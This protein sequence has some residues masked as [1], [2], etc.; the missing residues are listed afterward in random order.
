MRVLLI[1]GSYP[2]ENC[3]VGDYIASLARSLADLP[4]YEV[5]VLTSSDRDAGAVAATEVRAG[6]VVHRIVS[7]WGVSCLRQT[8][9][10]IKEIEPEITHVQYPTQG[11]ARRL[12]PLM[13]PL[14]CKLAGTKVVQTWHEGFAIWRFPRVALLALVPGTTIVVRP[15]FLKELHRGYR[16]ISRVREVVYIRSASSIPVAVLTASEERRLR[17]H[18][19]ADKKVLVFFGFLYPGKGVG[20]IFEFADPKQWHLVIAGAIPEDR[21]YLR[22]LQSRS[23]QP[24]WCGNVT[25]AGPLPAIEI[26][27]LLA[28]ADGIALPFEMGGGEWNSSLQ[29]AIANRTFVITTSKKRNGYEASTDT[30]Y[31]QPGDVEEMRRALQLKLT[32]SFQ[33]DRPG[34]CVDGWQRIAGE[35]HAVYREI[36]GK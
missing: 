18:Y 29:A 27:Q 6:P 23:Q 28:V 1:A 32:G 36:Q 22:E 31:A 8:L 34:Q 33:P 20:H 11:F 14:L 15:D 24:D 10:V 26:A 9:A 2:P 16:W 3:G 13:I 35:H 7:G 4:G 30:Y 21:S 19:P 25:F 12:F 17:S 5:H